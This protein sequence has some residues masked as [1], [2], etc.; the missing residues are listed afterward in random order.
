M[1]ESF[2]SIVEG[3][4]ILTWSDHGPRI[5]DHTMAHGGQ[6]QGYGGPHFTAQFSSKFID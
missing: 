3:G 2:V 4:E 5:T 6:W 1:R